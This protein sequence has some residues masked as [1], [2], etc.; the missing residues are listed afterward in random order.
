[1][2]NFLTVL[3]FI[4]AMVGSW[5][6][7]AYAYD[8]TFV[9]MR[10]NTGY[11]G[12]TW[13]YSGAGNP[14]QTAK[15]KELWDEGKRLTSISCTNNGWFISAAFNTG[16]TMQ[17]YYYNNAWPEQW[18][19]EG[20]REGYSITSITYGE[21][22]WCVV[23]SQGSKFS[24]QVH[25]LSSNANVGNDIKKY[26]DQG[27]RI[28]HA[29]AKDDMWMIVMAKNSPYGMQTYNFCTTY[30]DVTEFVK[31]KWDEKYLITLWTSSSSRQ[32]VVM[33]QFANGTFPLERYMYNGNVGDII[34]KNWNENYAICYVGGDKRAPAPTTVSAPPPSNVANNKP[35]VCSTCQGTGSMI[36]S[37]CHG[38]GLYMSNVCPVC[39][40][41]G[42]MVCPSCGGKKPNN[43]GRET[44]FVSAG[45]KN[46]DARFKE[47][48]YAGQSGDGFNV[49]ECSVYIDVANLTIKVSV[50][51][52]TYNFT[53]Q[54]MSRAVISKNI[55]FDIGEKKDMDNYLRICDLSTDNHPET[56]QYC[57][58]KS[59]KSGLDLTL[60]IFKNPAQIREFINRCNELIDKDKKK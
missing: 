36:C 57:F 2:K 23:M 13:A 35:G 26:W 22:K 16:Y 56:G 31:K 7:S 40:G 44:I 20:K 37:V 42:R 24:N 11:T 60:N 39:S 27:Y 14:L 4:L 9:I 12:D 3:F 45:I 32:L 49:G 59:K 28:T 38:G 52:H 43:Y 33:S 55:C 5:H 41:T 54:G 47:Y 50:P 58:I 51:G 8:D 46:L 18:V 29:C 1:M 53:I 48:K 10:Q 15:I 30:N 17:K 21:G 34:Q 25:F 19:A 6:V